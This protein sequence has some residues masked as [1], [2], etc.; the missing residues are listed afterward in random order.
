V[1]PDEVLLEVVVVVDA[2]AA[3]VVDVAPTD[4]VGDEPKV[5][6]PV[7]GVIETELMEGILWMSQNDDH[8]V[9]SFCSSKSVTSRTLSSFL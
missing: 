1:E 2:E 5:S 4:V 9:F 6:A 8:P 3:A 7:P